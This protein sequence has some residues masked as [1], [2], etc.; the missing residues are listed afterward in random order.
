MLTVTG[1][2]IPDKTADEYIQEVAISRDRPSIAFGLTI[3]LDWKFLDS[4]EGA[5]E[6]GSQAPERN[7][8]RNKLTGSVLE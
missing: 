1:E 6:P 3:E 4:L 8:C 5:Q 2:P 7:K